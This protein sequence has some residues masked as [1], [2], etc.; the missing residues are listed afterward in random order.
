MPP[1][2]FDLPAAAA[3]GHEVPQLGGMH[4]SKPAVSCVS[5]HQQASPISSAVL[6]CWLCLC[7]AVQG[8]AVEECLEHCGLLKLADLL[9]AANMQLA[10]QAVQLEGTAVCRRVAP[11]APGL[12]AGDLADYCA[13]A[14]RQLAEAAPAAPAA[15]A[16]AALAAGVGHQQAA[17]GGAQRVQ[18]AGVDPELALRRALALVLRSCAN[19]RCSSLSGAS[20]GAVRRRKCGGCGT[21]RYCG[22]ACCRADWPAHRVAC[23][24][25][26]RQQGS[27]A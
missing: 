8:L 6:R 16:T 20:E 4:Q 19:P 26:R 27:T 25:L 3:V 10:G 5:A 12:P 7:C 9:R 13:S 11:P 18:A 22:D 23:K 1:S 14:A 24:L 17:A 15:E 21:V 2:R